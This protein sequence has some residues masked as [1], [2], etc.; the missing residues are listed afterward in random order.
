MRAAVMDTVIGGRDDAE[1]FARARQIGCAGVEITASRHDLRDAKQT[2]LE[3]LRRARETTGLE[4]HALVLGEHNDR[5]GLADGNE[6]VA[7]PARDDV[8]DAIAWAHELGAQV[9][10]VPFFMR[11]DLGAQRRCRTCGR[12]VPIAVPDRR[13]AGSDALLRGNA[14]RRG[15][16][17][18]RRSRGLGGFRR[19]TSISRTRLRSAASTF[20]RRSGRSA[21]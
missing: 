13:R 5:G 17:R 15:D 4:V 16:P 6:D 10:L 8:R 14:P 9:I 21:R 19:A 12:R 20:P 11:A 2:R 1:V 18:A 7:G 3:T